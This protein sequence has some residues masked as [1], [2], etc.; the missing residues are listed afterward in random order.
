MMASN[1]VTKAAQWL[2]R[3]KDLTPPP[4]PTEAQRHQMVGALEFALAERSRRSRHAPWWQI[5][6]AASLLLAVGF[7]VGYAVLERSGKHVPVASVLAGSGQIEGS[8]LSLSS[9]D[10]VLG[11]RRIETGAAQSLEL[12]WVGLAHVK[13]ESGTIF[14]LLELGSQHLL[15]L[16]RGAV[17][18]EVAPLPVGSR[19]LVETR[20]VSVEV[21]GTAFRVALEGAA[22]KCAMATTVRVSHGLVAVRRGGELVAALGAGQSWPSCE[23]EPA[24][25]TLEPASTAPPPAAIS[26]K[27]AASKKGTVGTFRSGAHRTVGVGPSRTA[28]PL[29]PIATAGAEPPAGLPAP[30]SAAPAQ[31][32][33][34]AA[35]KRGAEAAARAQPAA[36]VEAP[37]STEVAARAEAAERSQAPEAS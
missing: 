37:A 36:R 1:V 20:D 22:N 31:G 24:R 26:P 2:A 12:A 5:S 34:H 21:R 28:R 7:G 17:S 30:S 15:R 19:L 25:A 4:E 23:D 13:A 18:L 3:G 6:V 9:G 8:G 16:E 14:A 11:E 35:S 33:E 29:A 27:R 32:S 10:T